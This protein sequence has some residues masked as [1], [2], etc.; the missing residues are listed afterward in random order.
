MLYTSKE[1]AYDA[2]RQSPSEFFEKYQELHRDE[3]ELISPDWTWYETRYHYN[4]VEN[5]IIDI[6]R[7]GG[8]AVIG[9]RI[10]D[11]GPGTGH[12][13]D[14]YGRILEAKMI[15][16]VDFSAVSVKRLKKRY[17]DDRSIRIF[18]GNIANHEPSW[19]R[20]FDIVNAIG[21]MFHIVD[22]EKWLRAIANICSYLA[23]RG[24]AIIGGDF[25]D[26]T[27]E[28]GVMRRLRS[29]RD[30]DA[31]LEAVGGRRISLKRFDWFKGGV[32]PG[33]KNN[34]LAFSRK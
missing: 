12:W 2:Y 29:L 22:D 11:V 14:F 26:A 6:L 15:V 28:A 21:V 17:S 16:G 24:V 32:N 34:L 20:A 4:L 7:E 5:G 19:R 9:K 25:G 8:E 23:E 31:A 1:Q 33:L 30:W 13:I 10:L 18:Q 27:E 3:R